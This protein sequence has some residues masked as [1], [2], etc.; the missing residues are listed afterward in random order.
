MLAITREVLP[1]IGQPY[2]GTV[3][4]NQSP[5]TDPTAPLSAMA[6]D[7]EHR[8]PSLQFAEGD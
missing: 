5:Q 8:Q 4:I 6:G 3:L 7:F 2:I 1:Q